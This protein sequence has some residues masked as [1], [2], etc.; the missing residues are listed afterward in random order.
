MKL[1]LSRPTKQLT[2]VLHFLLTHQNMT[3]DQIYQQTYI[4]GLSQ[5]ISDLRDLNLDV[6]CDEIET[7]NKF[8][9]YVSYGKWT[10]RNKDLGIELYEK[11]NVKD[12][13]IK[14]K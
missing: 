8:G 5:R 14:V 12:K 3:F 11:L 9:N 1:A 10:L 6:H 2:E 4:K 13:S 7:K